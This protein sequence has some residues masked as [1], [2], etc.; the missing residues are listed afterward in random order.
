MLLLVAFEAPE[1]LE[2]Y[3]VC[4]RD[5]VAREYDLDVSRF[6]VS[7]RIVLKEPFE[8]SDEDARQLAIWLAQPERSFSSSVAY[9]G[10]VSHSHDTIHLP[11]RGAALENALSELESDLAS[12]GLHGGCGSRLHA[13]APLLK[14]VGQRRLNVI[15]NSIEKERHPS[16]VS[17]GRLGIYRPFE[18]DWVEQHPVSLVA[19]VA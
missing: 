6:K 18:N 17:L 7:P 8:A 16:Q 14:N 4:A 13:R 9:V 10:D 12:L 11:I 15:L 3:C 19:S 2:R 5:R 1:S